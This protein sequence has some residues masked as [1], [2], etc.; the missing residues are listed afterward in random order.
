MVDKKDS[1]KLIVREFGLSTLSIN[2]RTS[3]IILTLIIVFL[4]VNAY[5]TIPKEM[6]PLPKLKY[7]MFMLVRHIL[8]IHRLI[9]RI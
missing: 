7:P 3:V 2:N 4:G 1:K 9:S 6:A 5:L 8:V